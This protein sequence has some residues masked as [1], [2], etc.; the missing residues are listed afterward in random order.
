[1][2][3]ILLINI[4][5]FQNDRKANVNKDLTDLL[6][7]LTL[8]VC[9][10]FLEIENKIGQLENLL[11][12][13]CA[14]SNINQSTKQILTLALQDAK[15]IKG[16]KANLDSWKKLESFSKNLE[17]KKFHAEFLLSKNSTEIL[18]FLKG[19]QQKI[20]S[21]FGR[22]SFIEWAM[23]M[24]FIRYRMSAGIIKKYGPI[25]YEN[26]PDYVEL[27]LPNNL[28][29][30]SICLEWAHRIYCRP[31]FIKDIP[32]GIYQEN[33]ENLEGSLKSHTIES[34]N[35]FL[36]IRTCK[37]YLI[38]NQGNF[39]KCIDEF[40][41]IPENWLLCSKTSTDEWIF[42]AYQLVVDSCVKLE[43]V[44]IATAYQDAYFSF[45]FTNYP[46]LKHI[47]GYYPCLLE[48]EKLR[49]FYQKSR[50]WGLVRNL[51]DRCAK[52]GMKPLPKQP[53]E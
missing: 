37:M 15:K 7:Q 36:E 27:V 42:L 46:T 26:I 16:Y 38:F 32:L 45:L 20:A 1:M 49:D 19:I 34:S 2:L 40:R 21:F 9:M 13:S 52:F 11:E 39:Q 33:L 14:P 30:N 10:N 50:E 35:K 25:L 3:A 29:E 28:K 6:G 47:D 53:G 18:I 41:D 17:L 43:K 48:A 44:Q 12:A 51:E 8:N 4:L 22:D 23:C 24:H 31:F 5:S